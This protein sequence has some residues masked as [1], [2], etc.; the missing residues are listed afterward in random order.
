MAA[1]PVGSETSP[2][3]AYWDDLARRSGSRARPPLWRLVA[4][5]VNRTLLSRWL[6]GG[7]LRRILKTDVFDELV[8]AGLVPTLSA[9][10]DKLIC[11]DLSS[12]AGRILQARNSDATIATADVR[13]LPFRDG[14]FDAVVSHSTL[15]HFASRAEIDTALREIRRVMR[16][17]S[18]FIVILDNPLHPI[19]VIRNALAASGHGLGLIPYAVGATYGP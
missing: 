13:A 19:V 2:P 16:P 11:I 1:R 6:P 17:G 14:A 7:R 3:V 8:T 12:E 9:Q 5:A 15:D 18:L 4:D 10:N